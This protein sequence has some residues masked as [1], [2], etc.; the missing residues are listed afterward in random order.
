[1]EIQRFLAS[2]DGGSVGKTKPRLNPNLSTYAEYWQSI[3]PVEQHAIGQYHAIAGAHNNLWDEI[4]K[5]TLTKAWQEDPRG[6]GSCAIPDSYATDGLDSVFTFDLIQLRNRRSN[7]TPVANHLNGCPHH[8]EGVGCV[9]NELK[10]PKCLDYVDMYIDDEIEQRFGICLMP[11]KPYLDRVGLAGADQSI[12]P[13]VLHPEV[14]DEFT[15]KTVA[16][17]NQ[18]TDYIKTFPILVP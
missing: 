14:N 9:L 3:D 16:A 11:V 4:Y 1:M 13:M 7:E 10:G 17:I 5:R 2:P 12:V 15:A 18:V 8:R 6:L